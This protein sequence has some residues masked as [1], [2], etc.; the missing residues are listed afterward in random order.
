MEEQNYREKVKH[1]KVNS[2]EIANKVWVFEDKSI[3]EAA[4]T[5][6]D[7]HLRHIA[8][9]DK[10]EKILGIIAASDI[11]NRVVSEG[12]DYKNVKV[13]DIMTKNVFFVK[14]EDELLD[15]YL[16]MIKRNLHSV[17][18][19]SKDNRFLG[20]ITFDC[21]VKKFAEFEENAK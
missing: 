17:P 3:E 12:K 11:V 8:V 13:K 6:R 2:C 9:L 19:V 7:S 16:N 18:V 10:N 1:L 15:A 5:I 14:E 4:K 21:I 20:F